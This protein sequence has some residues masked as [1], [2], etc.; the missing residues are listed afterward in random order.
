MCENILKIL[1]EMAAEIFRKVSHRIKGTA[2]R[3][4]VNPYKMSLKLTK[5]ELLEQASGKGA[6]DS[7]AVLVADMELMWLSK[8]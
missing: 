4:K 6:M 1:E 3:M 7:R 2:E 5:D 8:H